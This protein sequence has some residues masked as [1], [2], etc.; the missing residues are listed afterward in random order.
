MSELADQK[1][2][3]TLLKLDPEKV[4]YASSN[5]AVGE[6][7]LLVIDKLV[8]DAVEHA[9]ANMSKAD[10]QQYGALKERLNKISQQFMAH[11]YD[12]APIARYIEVLSQ[13]LEPFKKEVHPL[14]EKAFEHAIAKKIMQFN[15]SK[16]NRDQ[17]RKLIHDLVNFFDRF[18]IPAMYYL[19]TPEHREAMRNLLKNTVKLKEAL[20]PLDFDGT[21]EEGVISLVK[22]FI[23]NAVTSD[24]IYHNLLHYQEGSLDLSNL[25]LCIKATDSINY[26]MLNKLIPF[27]KDPEVIPSRED[28][29]KIYWNLSILNRE[30]IDRHSKEG[31]LL[32]PALQ[33]LE[34]LI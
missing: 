34:E 28:I 19:K 14:L 22:H 17:A 16:V 8:K 26:Y 23:F 4:C 18:L 31:A 33:A 21:L 2:L 27:L 25:E 6:W 1:G 9:P 3:S 32:F 13:K 29:I 10:L 15:L 20:D 30:L 7:N 5:R 12:S 11:D 24:R